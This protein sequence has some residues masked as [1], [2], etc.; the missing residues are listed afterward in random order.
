[1]SNVSDSR[2]T[3]N[4]DSPLDPFANSVQSNA[5]RLMDELFED[6]ERML[7]RGVK[8]SIEPEESQY[9]PSPPIVDSFP[10]EPIPVSTLSLLPKLS[11]RQLNRGDLEPDFE[12]DADLMLSTE[13]PESE[14]ERPENRSFDGLLLTIFV[15]TIAITVGL[16]FFIRH[17]IPQATTPMAVAPATDEMLK[18]QQDAQFL[19][20]VQRS[21]DR[22]DRAREQTETIASASPSPNASTTAP[23][24]LERIYIPVYQPP[25]VQN[26]PPVAALP[27]PVVPAA[28]L[29]PPTSSVPA[30]PVPALPS[31]SPST[32]V[33]PNIAPVNTHVLI[34]ILELGDRSAALFEIDGTPQRI[35]I[36]ER[37]GASGWTLV[38]VSGQEAI[39]RRNGE[40]RSVYIGQQF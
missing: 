16:W 19:D 14:P 32:A 35:Q 20:Y 4:T 39:V 13:L 18:N 3:M 40:V 31:P 6:V 12:P 24:V 22:I 36:G 34:G 17:R 21:I 11:P 38:S 23:T 9:Q 7:E 15:A 33:V 5:D 37:I 2:S 25:A 8:L 1:M 30:L 26:L 28:P 27:S 10:P 29:S